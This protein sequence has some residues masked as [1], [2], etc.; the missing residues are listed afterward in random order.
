MDEGLAHQRNLAK[1]KIAVLVLRARSNRLADTRPLMAKVLALL[2]T[3]TP[4]NMTM[5]SP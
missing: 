1:H 5:V 2:G 3:I 4:G